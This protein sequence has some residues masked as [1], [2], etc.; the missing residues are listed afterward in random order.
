LLQSAC[1]LR[2][3]WPANALTCKTLEFTML[4]LH[5]W[6]TAN[7]N[8]I[9]LFLEEAGLDYRV[10]PVRLSKGEQLLPD[11]QQLSPNNRIPAIL[12]LMPA[13]GGAPY[14]LF[15]SGAILQYLAEK[16]GRFM[17][18]GLRERHIAM[19]W[20]FWQVGGLGPMAGQSYHFKN[21]APEQV[22][23]AIERYHKE[24]ARLY[25]VLNRH[26]EDGREF[27]SG[28]E[29]SIADMACYPWIA[30]HEKQGQKLDDFPALARWAARV[31]A[32]PATQR[33]YALAD[34]V[35]NGRVA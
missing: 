29:Y 28:D 18:Q 6:P 5:Y 21:S 4:N 14:S 7:G 27:I 33:A 8:K 19:Q 31:A 9:A 2:P 34:E 10:F 23:Y 16:T 32:R 25:G 13:D 30:A 35:I 26:L 12:D 22:P 1:A 15:E 11:F 24:T 17:P 20:L 3:D